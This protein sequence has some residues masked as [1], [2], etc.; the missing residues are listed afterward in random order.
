MYNYIIYY[1]KK[2]EFE[3]TNHILYESYFIQKFK[4]KTEI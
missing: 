1:S 2:K 3:I 4:K